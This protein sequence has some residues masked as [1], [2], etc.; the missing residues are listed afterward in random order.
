MT[1]D[2]S[3]AFRSLDA[4]LEIQRKITAELQCSKKRVFRKYAIQDCGWNSMHAGLEPV[5][6]AYNSIHVSYRLTVDSINQMTGLDATSTLKKPS[7]LVGNRTY[8]SHVSSTCWIG[9]FTNQSITLTKK[10]GVTSEQEEPD[11]LGNL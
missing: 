6:V 10:H 3:R 4:E 5:L 8:W 11:Q 1:I 9:T 7:N 2:V